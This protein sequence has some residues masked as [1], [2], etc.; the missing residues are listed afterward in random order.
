MYKTSLI[1]SM[2]NLTADKLIEQS[3]DISDKVPVIIQ[4]VNNFVHREEREGDEYERIKLFLEIENAKITIT[5]TI[6]GID[7]ALAHMKELVGDSDTEYSR[8][9]EDILSY[10]TST[11]LSDISTTF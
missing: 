4:A 10:S 7:D 2:Y 8:Y 1:F 5:K 9:T 11:A 3:I 6:K